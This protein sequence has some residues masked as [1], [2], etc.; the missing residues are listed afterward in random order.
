MGVCFARIPWNPF[1]VVEVKDMMCV[2]VCGCVCVSV[3]CVP[4]RAFVRVCFARIPWG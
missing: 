2:Y 1:S 3:R 4:G